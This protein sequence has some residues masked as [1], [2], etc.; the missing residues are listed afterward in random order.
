MDRSVCQRPSLTAAQQFASS[1]G[2]PL[3]FCEWGVAIRSDGHGLGD[4]PYFI[5]Q[6]VSWMHSNDVTYESYFDA[7]SGGVNSVITGGSF[8]SSLAAF[9]ADLG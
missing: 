8:P 9:S 6:M 1:N 7:N 4:D 5:N 2:K 3:A